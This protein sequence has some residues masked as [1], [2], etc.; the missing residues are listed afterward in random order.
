MK[1]LYPKPF[2]DRIG[3]MEGVQVHIYTDPNVKP[4]QQP[5][6]KIPFHLIPA[7]KAKLDELLAQGIIEP[8]SGEV[9]WVSPMHPVDK[10]K[11]GSDEIKVRITSNN[12]QLNKAIISQKRD[13]PCVNALS[14]DLNGSSYFSKLD[15]KE[16]FLQLELD[17]A[18]RQLTTFATP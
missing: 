15:I 3:K 18:S 9:T 1:R 14:Y 8:A 6:Y 4:I 13:M 7:T 12:K 16:A 10:S 11:K 17:E 5:A 2:E